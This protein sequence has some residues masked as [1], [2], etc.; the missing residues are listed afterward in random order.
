MGPKGSATG[1]TWGSFMSAF[2]SAQLNIT[3]RGRLGPIWPLFEL[4]KDKN[5]EHSNVIKQWLDPLVQ[6]A[7]AEKR[8][9]EEM[10]VSSPIAEKNFLQHL[11]DSTDGKGFFLMKK[12]FHASIDRFLPHRPLDPVL[13]RDQLLSM[14]LASRDTVSVSLKKRH[15]SF[16][17]DMR[18]TDRLRPDIY[19]LLHGHSSRCHTK[20]A[21]RSS[22]TL[23][24]IIL[25]D[26]RK[27]QRYEI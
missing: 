25:S 10:E 1:D 8:R 17:I 9:S 12:M 4:F 16:S 21:C 20:V 27:F 24:S 22:P 23:R 2:E 18:L 3:K 5:E 7:L 13:I 26:I 11:A 15:H 14:L 19:H 6:R